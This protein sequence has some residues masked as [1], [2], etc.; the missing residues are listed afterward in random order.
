MDPTEN[1]LSIVDTFLPNNRIATVVERRAR[2]NSL[3]FIVAYIHVY[4]AVAW[5]SFDQ[6]CYNM[7]KRCFVKIIRYYYCNI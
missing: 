2:K 7:I 1:S 4:G 5:Q 3:P 6:I